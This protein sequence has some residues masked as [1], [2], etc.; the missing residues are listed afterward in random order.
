[1]VKAF[2]Y[3][4]NFVSFFKEFKNY[5]KKVLGLELIKKPYEDETMFKCYQIPILE[6]DVHFELVF[7]FND[8]N[9]NSK[10]ICLTFALHFEK[11]YSNKNFADD[12]ENKSFILKKVM[13]D[14]KSF[15]THHRDSIY[16]TLKEWDNAEDLIFW[17]KQEEYNDLFRINIY[18]ISLFYLYYINKTIKLLNNECLTI[19]SRLSYDFLILSKKTPDLIETLQRIEYETASKTNSS[20][21]QEI[22][23]QIFE[24]LI[25][26]AEKEQ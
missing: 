1:M 23:K 7:N 4:D 20:K 14:I 11:K 19:K 6:K 25:E 8:S 12:L 26:E 15:S 18:K 13:K 24:E 10:K 5:F 3:K 21:T 9:I 22:I 2:D 16:I 17:L